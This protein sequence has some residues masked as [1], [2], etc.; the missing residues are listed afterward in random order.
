VSQNAADLLDKTFGTTAVKGGLL[1]G[2]AT[3]TVNTK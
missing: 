1:V 3:I 2:V